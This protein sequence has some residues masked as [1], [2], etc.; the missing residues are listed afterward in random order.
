MNKAKVEILMNIVD[1]LVAT[2]EAKNDDYGDS[3]ARV[4]NKYG[5]VAILVRLTDKFSRLEALLGGAVQKVKD[6]SVEDT[7]LDMAAYCLMEIMER[8]YA[9]RMSG[10]T[11]ELEVPP[12]PQ[13]T[14]A[15]RSTSPMSPIGFCLPE[16][17]DRPISEE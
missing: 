8:K 1:T 3:F 5:N 4:R 6:E 7:L 16:L 13:H 15:E 14:V 9:M 17:K 10:R 2:Y 12:P 11:A